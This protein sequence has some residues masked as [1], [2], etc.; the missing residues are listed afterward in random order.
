MLFSFLTSLPPIPILTESETIM[1]SSLIPLL[2]VLSLLGYVIILLRVRYFGELCQLKP[3]FLRNLKS[4]VDAGIICMVLCCHLMYAL[5]KTL[6]VDANALDMGLLNMLN[7]TFWCMFLVV[8][9]CVIRHFSLPIFFLTVC[10]NIVTLAVDLWLNLWLQKPPPSVLVGDYAIG[11]H[12]LISV[13]AYS[14]CGLV[15]LQALIFSSQ[16]RGLRRHRSWFWF[17]WIPALE[18]NENLFYTLSHFA[19]WGLSLSILSGMI[20]LENWLA[21]HVSHKTVFTLLAWCIFG[22]LLKFR[23]RYNM[24]PQH[25]ANWAVGACLL[26]IIG[27]VGSKI[28]L[29]FILT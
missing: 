18:K 4:H 25:S 28:V 7:V 27:V 11:I 26:L 14:L 21:Q 10:L 3:S 24:T 23:K 6:R 22:V 12:A 5:S 2:G 29:E 19:F 20:V 8:Y 15:I 16:E 1:T 9:L 13:L 17:D